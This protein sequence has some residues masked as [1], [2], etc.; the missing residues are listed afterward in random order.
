MSIAMLT[1]FDLIAILLV[2]TATFAWV[3]HRFIGLPHSIGLLVMGLG[4]SLVLIGVE[5]AIPHVL[6]Y[7]DLA[8]IIRQFDFQATVLNGILAFL[9]FAGALH[10]DLARLRD[11]GWAVGSMA[12]VG[13]MIST[14]IVGIGFWLAAGA[15]GI[16]LPLAWALVFGALI[17]PTDPLAVISIL[18]A[19][20]VPGTLEIDMVGE[21]LFNDG[22][23]VVIFTVLVAAAAGARG[24]DIDLLDI[25]G[26]FFIEALGGAMLGLIAGYLAYRAMRAIDDYPIEVLISLALVTGTY[27]LAAKLHM[28]GPIAMVVAGLLIG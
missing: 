18:K 26:V 8:G 27:T 11:R 12:T 7:E 24:G 2:L 10:V 21:S 23:G 22:V 5:L 28:S 25:G 19:V 3:N 17:S 4:A 9:L 20:D 6:L 15:F 14:A 13:T 16:P 1:A